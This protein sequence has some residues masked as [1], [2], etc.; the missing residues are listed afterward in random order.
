MRRFIV[1]ACTAALLIG[2]S[3]AASA[4]KVKTQPVTLEC[5]DFNGAIVPCF[6]NGPSADGGRRSIAL[7]NP[8]GVTGVAFR[9][10]WCQKLESVQQLKI[11]TQEPVSAG[12]P[13]ISSWH[14]SRTSQEVQE[15]Q[16]ALVQTA[17][18]TSWASMSN[19]L[20]DR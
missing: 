8:D 7:D 5:N 4:G 6:S 11:A 3:P 19:C 15:P 14:M 20:G 12:T 1:V 9:N 18:S 13:R 10:W 2:F 17:T 16:S